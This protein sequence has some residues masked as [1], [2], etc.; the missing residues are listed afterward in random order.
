M[1]NCQGKERYPHLIIMRLASQKF[2]RFDSEQGGQVT[3]WL[4]QVV[5]EPLLLSRLALAYEGHMTMTSYPV[6]GSRCL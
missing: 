4:L 3:D 2:T 5:V 6:G 1:D